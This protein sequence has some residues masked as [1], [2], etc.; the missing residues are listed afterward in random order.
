[1]DFIPYCKCKETTTIAKK[2]PTFTLSF[3]AVFAFC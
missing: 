3:A 1:M 2:T